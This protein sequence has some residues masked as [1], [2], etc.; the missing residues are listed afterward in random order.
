LAQDDLFSARSGSPYD[1][2]AINHG[3]THGSGE[4]PCGMVKNR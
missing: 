4:T 3:Q 2:V 1:R